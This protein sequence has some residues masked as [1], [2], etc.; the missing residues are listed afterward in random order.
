MA[1]LAV[2]TALVAAAVV[3]AVGAEHGLLAMPGL[4]AL[5]TEVAAVALADLPAAVV[6]VAEQL[7]GTHYRALLVVLQLGLFRGIQ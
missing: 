1:L 3:P 4:P 6:G 5:I 7:T 2:Q